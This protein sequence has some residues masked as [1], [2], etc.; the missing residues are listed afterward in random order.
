MIKENF[1]DYLQTRCTEEG[2]YE[3]VLDD[4]YE[5]AFDAWLETKDVNDI[6]DYGN[7]AI[8]IIKEGKRLDGIVF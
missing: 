6:I 5:D 2:G 7:Q 3:G 8:K 4:D 1:E